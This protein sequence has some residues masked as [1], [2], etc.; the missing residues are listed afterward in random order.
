VLI[1]ADGR[2]D[3]TKLIGAFRDGAKTPKTEVRVKISRYLIKHE[4]IK[5]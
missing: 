1:D 2:T 4:A 5:A 3:M